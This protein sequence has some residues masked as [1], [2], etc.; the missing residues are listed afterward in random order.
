MVALATGDTA[1]L[2][3]TTLN[4]NCFFIYKTLNKYY[5]RILVKVCYFK[6]E[7]KKIIY[8]ESE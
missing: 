1:T 8:I 7:F 3:A 2:A 4:T 5:G 6:K